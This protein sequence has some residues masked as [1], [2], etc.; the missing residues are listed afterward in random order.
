MVAPSFIARAALALTIALGGL[1]V[2]PAATTAAPAA[3]AA[4]TDTVGVTIGA[5]DLDGPAIVEVPVTVRNQS[6][7]AL[8]KLTVSLRGPV[9]W[10]VAPASRSVSGAVKPGASATVT[11]SVRVP[12]RRPGFHLRTFTATAAYRGGDGAGAAVGTRV[13]RSG[14]PMANLAAAFNNT[15]VTDESA[16][17]AGNFDGAGNS[18]SAQKLADVGLG[19][20][21]EV[22]ALGATL[23]MP[24][25]APGT[26]DNVAGGGQA[27]KVSGSGDALVLLGS[28]SSFGATGTVTVFYTDGT[29]STDETG[30]PNWSFQ[31]ADA[32]GATLVASSVGR[33][34]PDGYGD[35][36]Y[37]YR[38]FANSVPLTAG[39]TVDFVVLPAN[40]ALH[41]FAM[42][43][44][45]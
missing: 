16:T 36:A 18:F 20:G 7:A 44:A 6:T 15:G 17:T 29:S 12:E 27:V 8:R 3:A 19:R 38:V 1:L 21:A 24:D 34:R 14:E 40:S 4:T 42:G 5:V 37:Q 41:V 13:E 25:V 28:G 32:H 2:A 35:A 10:Q 31:E 33:N 9:G 11:F 43:L 26:A 30:M 22:E 45:G 39:K 23:T